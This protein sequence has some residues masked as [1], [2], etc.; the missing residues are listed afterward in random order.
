M[1]I[2]LA[3]VHPTNDELDQ[4]YYTVPKHRSYFKCRDWV[5]LDPIEVPFTPSGFERR[6]LIVYH[7]YVG[8]AALV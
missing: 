6:N 1:L 3:G 8:L 2:A 5:A 7:S 4:R